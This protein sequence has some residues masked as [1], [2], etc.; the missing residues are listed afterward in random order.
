MTEQD[1]EEFKKNVIPL[2]K[3][4]NLLKKKSEEKFSLKKKKIKKNLRHNFFTVK[5]K[6]KTFLKRIL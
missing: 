2:E 3:K 1:W 4:N 6:K 5:M